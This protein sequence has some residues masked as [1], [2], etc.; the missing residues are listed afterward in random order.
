M[1]FY[2]RCNYSAKNWQTGFWLTHNTSNRRVI[3]CE[4]SQWK[5]Q[6]VDFEYIWVICE[7]YS[8]KIGYNFYPQN[9]YVPFMIMTWETFVCENQN[10]AMWVYWAIFCR[11]QLFITFLKHRTLPRL[12]MVIFD[13]VVAVMVAS[14][15]ANHCLLRSVCSRMPLK[16]VCS[17][18]SF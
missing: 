16:K 10:V 7:S 9:K 8:E 14:G 4:I 3:R 2:F 11:K 5:I 15:T 1:T 17:A 12:V 6:P 13:C 18:S